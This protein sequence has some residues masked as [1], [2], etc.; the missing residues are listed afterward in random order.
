MTSLSEA[1]ERCVDETITTLESY[2]AKSDSF[3]SQLYE[4]MRYSLMAGG[5]RLRPFLV[6][7]SAELFD[8]PRSKALP[9]AAAIEMVHTYS[10]I[11]DDLPAMDNDDFRRGKP[12]CHKQFGEAIAILAG[13]AL[14]TLAFQ[15]VSCPK[16]NNNAAVRSEITNELA[17]AAGAA[18]MVGGQ[19]IDIAAETAIKPLSLNN[20]IEMQK[21][22][23]GALIK[24]ACLA[25]PILGAQKGIR[26]N[27]LADYAEKIGL[28]FQIVDDLLDHEGDEKTM[29]KAAGKDA[30]AGK[31]TFVSLLG[32]QGARQRA[33][34]L[35]SEAKSSLKVFGE[36]S[37]LL[38]DVA[39]Y[40]VDRE[41]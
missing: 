15:I 9:I 22:K 21:R 13:D 6:I 1:M 4:A 25:G 31:A 11:H 18:G 24:F 2:I 19:M 23:T 26:R 38:K 10:L 7:S 29:G 5:K 20:V 37:V 14:L 3:D 27:A 32:V 12:T 40:I 16:T 28:A 33:E 39:Q 34:K 30:V 8:I 41:K 35:V 17:L 36:R